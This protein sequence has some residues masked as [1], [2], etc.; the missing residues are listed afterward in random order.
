MNDA[1]YTT[2]HGRFGRAEYPCVPTVQ[3]GGGS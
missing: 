3:G 1:E 2:E